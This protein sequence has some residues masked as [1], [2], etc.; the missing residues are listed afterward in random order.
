MT[1][2]MR[3][4]L[5]ATLLL[6]GCGTATTPAA[7][8]VE[9][10]GV[11]TTRPAAAATVTSTPAAGP[12]EDRTLPA[13]PHAATDNPAPPTPDPVSPPSAP[14]P[15]PAS[16]LPP[17]D[18]PATPGP[19]PLGNFTIYSNSAGWDV[20]GNPWEGSS[21]ST[22]PGPPATV[23]LQIDRRPDGATLNCAGTVDPPDGHTADGTI[24][25]TLVADGTS[26]MATRTVPGNGH[27]PT[28]LTLEPVDVD[29]SAHT[30]ECH[31][32]HRA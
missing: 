26:P 14:A 31:L 13:T 32:E 21:T 5:A 8:S 17:A 3:V 24:H 10:L 22:A 28:R 20:D 2:I 27:D 11:S 29:S 1:A 9:V 19:T 15:T 30:Y 6:A 16:P 23:V 4:A 12:T 18:S 7:D 25:L